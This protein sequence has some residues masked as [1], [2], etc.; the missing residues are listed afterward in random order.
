VAAEDDAIVPRAQLE[1]L[2]GEL[3]AE[4]RLVDLP[5]RNGH[6]AFLTEPDA[7]GSILRNA[8]TGS[9]LS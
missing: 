1:A 6:D 8:L 7:L 2:A 3:G 4:C 5:S 9:I